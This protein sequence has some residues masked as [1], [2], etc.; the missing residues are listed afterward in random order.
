MC[1]GTLDFVGQQKQQLYILHACAA[2]LKVLEHEITLMQN[3]EQSTELVPR[4]YVYG[5]FFLR[6][7][8]III[9]GEICYSTEVTMY[10]STICD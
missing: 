9:Q 4:K 8:F 5:F 6:I 3:S 7:I 10:H 1:L 2:Y